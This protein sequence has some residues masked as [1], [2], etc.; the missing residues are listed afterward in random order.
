M[1]VATAGTRVLAVATA[2]AQADDSPFDSP[3][4][5]CYE[6]LRSM[7]LVGAGAAS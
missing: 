2:T 6:G 5:A 7:T 3:S 4:P 1:R